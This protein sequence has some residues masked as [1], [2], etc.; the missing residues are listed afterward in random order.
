MGPH[1]LNPGAPVYVTTGGAGENLWE[2][3]PGAGCIEPGLANFTFAMRRQAHVTRFTIDDNRITIQP[4]NTAGGVIDI[5]PAAGST[6][7]TITKTTFASF[8]RG[9]AN[10]DGTVNLSDGPFTNNW[11]FDGKP[12][13]HCLDAADSNDD[14]QVNVSDSVFTLNFLFGGGQPPPPPG[15]NNC[16]Q[17]PTPDLG[18]GLSCLEYASCP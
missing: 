4:L 3:L 12:A 15:P 7:S 14:G 5:D 13:P 10:Q 9:D 11:L 8:R 6:S 2:C 18:T 16:G 1:F 17:D